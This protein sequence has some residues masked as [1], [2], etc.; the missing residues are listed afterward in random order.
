[1]SSRLY[2]GGDRELGSVLVNFYTHQL[3]QAVQQAHEAALPASAVRLNDA[4]TD[5]K[6]EPVS[7]GELSLQPIRIPVTAERLMVTFWLLLA[8]AVLVLAA[9]ALKVS[10]KSGRWEGG[11]LKPKV[12]TIACTLFSTLNSHY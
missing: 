10:L 4:A 3:V 8:A 12:T 7:L 9:G 1:M 11:I 5:V 2:Q 6:M